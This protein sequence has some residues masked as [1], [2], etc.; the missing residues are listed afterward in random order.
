MKKALSLI[1]I[2]LI[3]GFMVGYVFSSMSKIG[4]KT[5][6]CGDGCPDGTCG[7]ADWCHDCVIH[8]CWDSK[9]MEFFDLVCGTSP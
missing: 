2:L 5:D 3:C 9:T 4:C 1:L 7:Q 6:D 8:N